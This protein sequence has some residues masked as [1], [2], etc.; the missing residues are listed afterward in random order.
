MSVALRLKALRLDAGSTQTDIAGLLGVSREAY[1]M[2]ETG[3]RQLGFDALG[4]L[5]THYRVTTDYLLGRTQ[6]PHAGEDL[7]QEE[8]ALLLRYRA[9]DA[10]GRR[11]VAGLAELEAIWLRQTEKQ[12][13]TAL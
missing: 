1:S 7:T 11:A 2:Y 8:R 12:D 13:Q 10:R 9:L 4:I 3:R 5:A 6:N